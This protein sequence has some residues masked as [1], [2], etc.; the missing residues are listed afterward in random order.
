MRFHLKLKANRKRIDLS[1]F[2]REIE[3]AIFF[4]F[5]TTAVEICKEYFEITDRFDALYQERRALGREIARL[6]PA[7][8]ACKVQYGNSS[9]LFILVK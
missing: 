7:L 9:Q 8:N 2:S 6:C 1:D 5:G 4:V 3:Q